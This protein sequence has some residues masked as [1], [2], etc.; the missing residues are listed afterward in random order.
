[1][2]AP[3]AAQPELRKTVTV[4]FCDLTDATAL[5]DALDAER[6]RAVLSAYYERM[7]AIVERHGGKV[8][9]FIGD[10]V[11]AVFGVPLLH[12]DDALRAVRAAAEMRAALPEL[13]LRGR[14]GVTTGEVVTGS[15]QALATGDAMNV[16][17]RLQQA[18]RPGEVLVAGRT[19]AVVRDAVVADPVGPLDLKGKERPVE[20]FRLVEVRDVPDR[21]DTSAFVGRGREMA[22]L[23]DAWD[24]VRADRRCELVTVVG[25]AGVGKS[26][27]I[28]EFLQ[29][30]VARSVRGRC[31]PYG[32]GITY[33]P[34]VEVLMQLGTVPDDP[35]VATPID[36]L[37]RKTSAST[38]ADELAWAF[39][40]T[41][42]QAAAD[43]LVLV[44]D[45]IQ[46]GEPGFLDLVEHVAVLSSGV[47]ILVVCMARPEL[48]EHRSGWPI[49][50]QLDGLADADVGALIPDRL[51]A[52]LR[53]RIARA[54]GGNP[55]FIEEMLAVAA[56]TDGEMVV[57]ATL[58][59]LLGARLDQLA[60][61]ERRALERAAV[62][63]EVFHLGAVQALS[64]DDAS[65]TPRLAAL[66]R[67][68]LIRPEQP[69]IAGEDGFRFRHL[70][71]RD[72]AYDAV[73]KAARADLHRAFAEW[74]SR[75]W[76]ELVE[77]DEIVG[78]HLERALAYRAELG[79]P[80]DAE[81]VAAAFDHLKAAGL[82]ADARGDAA[83]AANL[84]TRA[85]AQLE[86]GDVD[87][88][89]EWTAID[90]LVWSGGGDEALRR[91][92][93]LVTRAQAA[94]DHIAEL[95]G[96]I[97]A[98]Y[99][100]LWTRPGANAGDLE[101]LI[102]RALPV[103]DA[104]ENPVA[105]DV[106]YFTLAWAK[107]D[108]GRIEEGLEAVERAAAHRPERAGA[109]QAW[110]GG[111]RL[112]GPP[113]VAELLAW[114]D[115]PDQRDA[116]EPWLDSY[117]AQGLAMIGRVEEGRELIA[118]TI[119]TSTDR[120]AR[121]D[122]AVFT[123]Q[124]AAEIELLAGDPAAAAELATQGANQ[125]E[126]L[127]DHY[128]RWP[129]VARLGQI[130]AILGRLDEAEELIDRVKEAAGG[131]TEAGHRW[132]S[133][134]ALVLA[135]RG[136]HD[137][138][139]DLARRAVAVA[140]TSDFLNDRAD[141]YTSLADVLELGGKH[142]GAAGALRAALDLYDRKGNLVMSERVRTRLAS[143][144]VHA[145]DAHSQRGTLRR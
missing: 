70:L 109:L 123:G 72:A 94:G 83:A 92:G 112:D 101:Q 54:A 125:L 110:R 79:L 137:E 88:A 49:T 9:K 78:Y 107:Q 122:V 19:L 89:L 42:E 21:A 43:P 13:G 127:G 17:A 59:A 131:G 136:R 51:A 86:P 87:L 66:V 31:L 73:P 74:V 29:S 53:E 46:W 32:D 4:L 91:A 24:R 35:A 55:L 142:D 113:P 143:P 104:A 5:G 65:L 118:V 25:E 117:R 76:P 1:V 18:A 11:V 44:F 130:L 139:E 115:E 85:A 68:G 2:L 47:P 67:R 141:A 39:R 90:A 33:W 60:P 97:A 134:K 8:E 100:R 124:Q 80:R 111:A 128:F 145:A 26:R 138:A 27:L 62:E 102:E 22:V 114:L 75:R 16:A 48:A 28:A 121:L 58:Q 40:K 133:A 135:R 69:Q 7:K 77:L 95:C 96:R 99:V 132:Q 34:V 14:I 140:E 108:R 120:G 15:G 41:V 12:E 45:D 30:V 103:F 3:A 82:R 10:A 106:A 37:L 119:A 116:R 20:A 50:L 81:V 71:I 84:L 126:A 56:A 23:S 64:P 52:D 98:G 63:G 105:L 36:A 61:A 93:A 144:D 57:P 129:I 6:V 38:S